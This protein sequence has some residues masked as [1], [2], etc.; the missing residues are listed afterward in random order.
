[1]LLLSPMQRLSQSTLSLNLAVTSEVA[2][3]LTI[4]A[5][6]ELRDLFELLPKTNWQHLGEG[7]SI[8]SP[9]NDP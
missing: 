3:K 4:F 1:M 9:V 5:F 8:A 2:P 6:R 7:S